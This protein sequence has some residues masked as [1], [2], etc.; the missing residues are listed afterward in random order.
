MVK[1]LTILLVC[2]SV[3][4]CNAGDYKVEAEAALALAKAK[5]CTCHDNLAECRAESI[6]TGKPLVLSVN[7]GCEGFSKSLPWVIFCKVKEYTS[8]IEIGGNIKANTPR[9]IIL[10]SDMKDGQL[11]IRKTLDA[12][13]TLQ[14]FKPILVKET[15]VR[16]SKAHLNWE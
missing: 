12:K 6:K 9:F 2:I 1:Y 16:I 8:D 13:I 14:D 5:M 7:T 4:Y 10:S 3:N 15:K 11:Y